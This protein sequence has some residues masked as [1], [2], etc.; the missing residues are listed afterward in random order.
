MNEPAIYEGGCHC[1]AV[2]FRVKVDNH[3]ATLCNCS[4]C[5]KKGFVHLIVPDFD[6]TL[7][8]GEESL[9]TYTFNTGT[10]KHKFCRT[11][12][13]HSFYRPRSHPEGI[14]VNIRCL[15]SDVIDKFEIVRF[16]GRNWEK[17]IE[18]L[19]SEVP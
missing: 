2:R 13:I 19:R 1:G 8:Q 10:A 17:N 11:C 15:D 4:I 12:G 16:D 7:L 5:T 3:Q 6:F 18:N 14:S 9:T